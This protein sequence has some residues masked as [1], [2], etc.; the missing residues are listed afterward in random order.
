MQKWSLPRKIHEY[1]YKKEYDKALGF[2]SKITAI[3][4]SGFLRMEDE[5]YLRYAGAFRVHLLIEI[6]YYREALAW[7]CLESELYPENMESVIFKENLK[8]KINNL[9]RNTMSVPG[10][11]RDGW[12]GVAGMREVKT[13]IEQE[14]IV[15][16][17]NPVLYKRYKVP[18]PNGYLF[19]GPSGCGKTFIANSLAKK[20]G[21]N[22][23]SINPGD[24]GSTYVHGT[25]LRIKELFEDAQRKAPCLLFFDEFESMAPSRADGNVSFH[26]KAE[27]NELLTQ[28]NKVS[29][30]GIL[31]IAATNYIRNIDQSVL[32]PGRID[33]K[34]FI[35]PPDFEA[36]IESFKIQL[37]GR[38]LGKLN[39]DYIAEMSE[40]FTHADIELICNEAMRA[41]IAKKKRI[42]TDLLG[43]IIHNYKPS[44]NEKNL[45]AYYEEQ[46]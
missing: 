20:I 11:S 33:K 15:P 26:Y 8:S 3:N 28:L 45:N 1:I 7:A 17:T 37:K 36:R 13:I 40:Y 9:P 25:Q 24:I 34:I 27:V 29:E 43:S 16:Y 4:D 5:S 41:S 12:E 42:G 22:F 46:H 14:I 19:Y 35:G 23:I 2:L 30:K 31:F 32:R 18:L 10:S 6:G 21:F 38:P 44:L 39:L